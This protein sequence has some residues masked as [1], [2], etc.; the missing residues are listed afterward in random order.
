MK[1]LERLAQEIA[2]LE[3]QLNCS[4]DYLTI[5]QLEN[6]INLLFEQVEQIIAEEENISYYDFENLISQYL[7]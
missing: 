7:E 6:Q 1:S 4:I 5:K 3:K 2:T